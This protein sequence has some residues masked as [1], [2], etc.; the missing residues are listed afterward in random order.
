MCE[1][2]DTVPVLVTVPAYLSHTGKAR[3]CYKPIDRCLALLVR[4]LNKAGLATANCCCGH[5]KHRPCINLAD[6]RAIL[7]I[8][9][10]EDPLALQLLQS[11]PAVE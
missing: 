1:W 9:A 8:E 10:P 2:G 11:G 3:R 6:G 5:G 7:I 4:A